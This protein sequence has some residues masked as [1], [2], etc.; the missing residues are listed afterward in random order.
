MATK[1][2]ITWEEFIAAGKEGQRWECVNGEVVFMSPVFRPHGRVNMRLDCELE[3]YTRL[4]PEWIGYGTDTAFTMAGGNWRCPDAALVRKERVDAA[5][6]KG[7]A[8][9]APDIAF[10]ILSPGDT[11][12]EVQS[13]RQDYYESH[14]VQVWLDPERKTAEVVSTALPAL[15]LRANQ[16]LTLPEL[17]GFRLALQ[18]LF[19]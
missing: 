11:V 15:L 16:A 2:G 10:E 8:P 7:P 19:A 9:F 14:V 4:H 18:S 13:K 5:D 17:P 12:S 1:T 6:P 3:L